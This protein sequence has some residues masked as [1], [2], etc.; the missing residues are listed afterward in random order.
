MN[1]YSL[2]PDS[3]SVIE[4]QKNWLAKLVK[5]KEEH[6][7]NS[8]EGNFRFC[9]E[10]NFFFENHLFLS[11]DNLSADLFLVGGNPNHN[12]DYCPKQTWRR[13]DKA[14]ETSDSSFEF[15]G[16]ELSIKSDDDVSN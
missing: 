1:L 10:K 4:T 15:S 8:A 14:S 12:L 2:C 6:E 13:S 3:D 7:R 11:K 16:D 5:E 9:F